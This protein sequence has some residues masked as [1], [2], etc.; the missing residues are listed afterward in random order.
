M[1]DLINILKIISLVAFV[2]YMILRALGPTKNKA[3]I[4]ESIG[5]LKERIPNRPKE[6]VPDSALYEAF[7]AD[8]TNAA[9]LT[10]LAGGILRHC[11]MQPERLFVTTKSD[12]ELKDAAG[13]YQFDGY[14][15]TITI[16]VS[17]SAHYNIVFSVLIHECM[18]YFLFRSG[19]EFEDSYKNE[20]L[21]DTA[22]VYM[23]FF[24]YM[25]KG[26]VMVGYL[27]DSELKYVHERI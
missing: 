4:D 3:A 8:C 23:G 14:R 19:I 15:S 5:T 11:G 21:T 17:P 1:P 10:E 9:L 24:P 6:Y 26:Y 20:I 27:R 18:H 22:S 7:Q 25:F 2:V 16:R 12:R 13:T